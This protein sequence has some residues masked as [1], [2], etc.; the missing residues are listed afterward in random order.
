[1]YIPLSLFGQQRPNLLHVLPYSRFKRIDKKRLNLPLMFPNAIRYLITTKNG[2]I[3]LTHIIPPM[4]ELK[5]HA[6][7]KWHNSFSH[8]TNDCNDFCGQIQLAINEGQL[9]FQEMQV[10]TQPFPV[11]AIEPTCKEVLVRPEV[12]DKGKGENIVIS[13][14]RT[15]N[16]SQEEIA[17]KAPNK[18]TSKSGGA[19]GQTQLRSRARQPDPSIANGPTPTCGRSNA[20]TDSPFD[21]A[22]QS[23][24]G[25]R[26]QCPHKA[27]K[28]TQ[29]QS[30][31]DTHGRLV[32]A[33]PTFVQMLAKYAGKKVVL[34]DRPTKK[35]R[36]PTKTK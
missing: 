2:N 9:A 31:H 16:I 28:E 34:C 23:A 3:K 33:G 1:M 36:S 5:R 27:R 32:K 25:Q 30:Q 12:V 17:R 18:K 7:C 8:A 26:R 6:Y 13:D 35:P 11:N 4:V 20:Q 21:S 24:H 29:G 19:R 10:D 15:S 14:P 22:R